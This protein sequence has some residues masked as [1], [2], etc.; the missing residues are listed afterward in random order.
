VKNG[1]ILSILSI[2]I[3][4]L[5]QIMKPEFIFLLA[6]LL[7]LSLTSLTVSANENMTQDSTLKN[8]DNSTNLNTTLDKM[9]TIFN[10]ST[11]DSDSNNTG[12]IKI[13]N[14]MATTIKPSEIIA[15][16]LLILAILVGLKF[17]RNRD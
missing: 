2:Y 8:D 6:I 17:K 11:N 1:N 14:S 3:L 15:I 12:N 4:A 10:E 5:R 7:A 9:S 13:V 16:A